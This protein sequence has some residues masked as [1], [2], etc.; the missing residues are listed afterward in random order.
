MA[1]VKHEDNSAPQGGGIWNCIIVILAIGAI[2]LAIQSVDKKT[3]TDM[4][5]AISSTT[6]ELGN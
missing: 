3:V 2:Y 5:G 6:K 1:N 4:T